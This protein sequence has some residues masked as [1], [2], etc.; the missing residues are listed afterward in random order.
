MLV[1]DR[2]VA[3]IKMAREADSV[4]VRSTRGATSSRR[5]TKLRQARDGS[6][7]SS[8]CRNKERLALRP[9]PNARRAFDAAQDELKK[10]VE[11]LFAQAAELAGLGQGAPGRRCAR[12]QASRGT[13]RLLDNP[14]VPMDVAER[15]LRGAVIGRR[16]L[17]PARTARSATMY[18]VIGSPGIDVCAGWRRGQPARRTAQTAGRPVP[19]LP[20][21]MSEEAREFMRRNDRA[22][23]AA[24]RSQ[25]H[26]RTMALLR[27]LIAADPRPELPF[28]RV[29]PAYRRS[30]PTAASRT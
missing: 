14:Q 17:R 28:P 3:Y 6:S 30:S 25:L 21:T 20:W 11:E 8:V 9:R 26:R 13:E 22:I 12:F 4:L 29:L 7:G 18:L 23:S 27:A 1:C 16:L 19:W 2:Y 5:A 10:A 15:E 24:T